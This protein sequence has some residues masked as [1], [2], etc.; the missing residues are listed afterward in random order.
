M[1]AVKPVSLLFKEGETVLG[2]LL[3]LRRVRLLH[4]EQTCLKR[5]D[6]GN[7]VRVPELLVEQQ[8]LGE[9]GLGPLI[10]PLF[11]GNTRQFGQAPTL[12]PA[13]AQLLK[14]SGGLLQIATGLGELT[15]ETGDITQEILTGGDPVRIVSLLRERQALLSQ[16]LER[17]VA[18]EE[19][20]QFDGTGERVGLQGTRHS[21][22]S[23]QGLLQEAQPF[24]SIATVKPETAQSDAQAQGPLGLARSLRR[25]CLLTRLLQEIPERRPQVLLLAFQL[26]HPPAMLGPTQSRCSL[27]GQRQVIGGMRGSRLLQLPTTL[28][29]L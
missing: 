7:A 3:C 5:G 29:A 21:L 1:G 14:G 26:G 18:R 25:T 6:P 19:E 13:V 2:Q 11:D 15:S 23:G 24:S 8:A 17:Q 20:R 4:K 22:G 27:L 9:Q 10:L 28:Q 16:L 12:F